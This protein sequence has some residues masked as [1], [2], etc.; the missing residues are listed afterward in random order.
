MPI[1][2]SDIL[3]KQSG[4]SNLG[5]AIS[6]TDVSTALHGLFDVVSG[7]ESLA[8]DVEY[9][10]IYVKNNHGTLTL[11]N[12]VAFIQTN[13]PSGYTSCDI[14]LGTSAINGTE[15]TIANESAAP[16]GVSFSAPSAYASGLLIGDLAPGATKAIWIRR[17]IN[18]GAVA[19]NNDGMT[20]AVQGDTAA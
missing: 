6:G 7:P 13:T 11:Y 10:C 2:T 9:R 20:L 14:G 19:Y 5:G 1:L 8:G 17:T 16:S 4:A 3:F 12:A 18:A 15:Q